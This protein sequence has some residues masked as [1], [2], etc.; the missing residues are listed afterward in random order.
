MLFAVCC[1][2]KWASYGTISHNLYAYCN[3]I[4][5]VEAQVSEHGLVTPLCYLY[6]VGVVAQP[7]S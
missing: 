6:V 7:S 1:L 4:T 3:V 5:G 2:F